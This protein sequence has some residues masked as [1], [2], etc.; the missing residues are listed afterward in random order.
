MTVFTV[1]VESDALWQVRYT[2]LTYAT[3]VAVAI[4]LVRTYL[5]SRVKICTPDGATAKIWV[6]E[7][8]FRQIAED[9]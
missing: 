1:R 4:D 6:T 3:A 8:H 2:G 7:K 9:L 5:F